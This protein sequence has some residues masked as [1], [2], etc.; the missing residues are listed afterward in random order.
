MTGK[1]A[2]N[3]KL[4]RIFIGEQDKVGHRPLYE[5]LVYEARK[6]GLAGATVLRGVLSFGA[7]SR[8]HAAKL[9]ELS[10][11]LPIVVEIIDQTK[12]IDD[13]LSAANQLIEEAG[14]GALVTLETIEV[15]HYSPRK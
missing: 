15:T 5:A 12:T 8:I 13:F 9:L 6:R 11:D 7:S 4:L 2:K 10:T 14:C 3:S 1:L